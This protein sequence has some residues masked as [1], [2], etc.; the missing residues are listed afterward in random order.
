MIENTSTLTHG[1]GFANSMRDIADV[2]EW[3]GV[4]LIVDIYNCWRERDFADAFRRCLPHVQ[5]VQ[6]SDYVST[7]IYLDRPVPGDGII[8]YPQLIR[9]MLEAG[10]QGPFD[11]EVMGPHVEAEGVIAA[12]HRGCQQLSLMLADAGA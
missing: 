10:Y 1:T 2:A 6:V 9:T 7:G 8:P 4:G 5:V 12:V 11:L 3:T